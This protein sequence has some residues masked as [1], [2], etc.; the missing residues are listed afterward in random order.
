MAWIDE[1]WLRK[2]FE[3]LKATLDVDTQLK[4]DMI[5]FL[6]DEGFWDKERLQWDSAVARFNACLNP[7]K[8]DFFKLGEVWA[9]MKRFCRHELFLAMAE[10]LG[11]E[12]RA[13]PTE[14]RRLELL[15]R[16][17]S[18]SEK[19]DATIAEATRE[20]VRINDPNAPR[21]TSWPPP[22][23]GQRPQFSMDGS[24]VGVP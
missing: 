8:T 5:Q 4:R 1:G 21:S 12:V 13:K 24:R 23:P 10:D 14:E 11:Y 22:P 15:E 6:L 2:A 19:L 7:N 17:A 18:A 9:L 3:S 20:M 16:I